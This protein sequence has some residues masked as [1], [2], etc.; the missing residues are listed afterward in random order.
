MTSC[1]RCGAR[2]VREGS[3]VE[4]QNGCDLNAPEPEEE[5]HSEAV[6]DRSLTEDY[7]LSQVQAAARR[8][9]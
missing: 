1:S 2:L 8:L 3:D 5:Q 7:R 6:W 9:K 4:C